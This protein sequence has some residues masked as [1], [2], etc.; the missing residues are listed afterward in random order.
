MFFLVFWFPWKE[1]L[2]TCFFSNII[3]LFILCFFMS[4]R[5]WVFFVVW[6]SFWFAASLSFAVWAVV[7]SVLLRAYVWGTRYVFRIR[8]SARMF[9]GGVYLRITAPTWSGQTSTAMCGMQT[10]SLTVREHNGT[11]TGVCYGLSTNTWIEF[12]WVNL[13]LSS[14]MHSMPFCKSRKEHRHITT[15]VLWQTWCNRWAGHRKPL[16]E[17]AG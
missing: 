4:S 1:C 12:L 9:C 13:H 17:P 14:S 7:S 3:F 16:W 15:T 6:F 10:F 8:W 11:L 5:I 2:D